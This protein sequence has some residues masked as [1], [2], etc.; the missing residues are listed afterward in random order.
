MRSLHIENPDELYVWSDL[1]FYHKR[2]LEYCPDRPWK[3]MEEM[4]QG[5]I[6]NWNS[7]VTNK[8]TI[9][10]LGD[11][12]FS[13]NEDEVN[14]ILKKLN[15]KKHIIWGNHDYKLQKMDCAKRHFLSSN[16]LLKIKVHDE[17]KKQEIVC[18]HFAMKIWEN[19][20]R[21]TWHIF[22]HSHGS[23]P[24]DITSLSCDVGV[25]AKPWDHLPVSYHQLKAFMATKQ[26]K[27][28]DHHG[29]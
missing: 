5:L 28:I 19:S 20:H 4:N 24:D 6:D 21:G 11:F 26:Y 3:N 29:D 22:G 14:S 8:D 9:V 7:K 18:C 17:T 10:I 1:H 23:M 2:I 16:D 15:G 12:T 27:S 25:D 13:Q